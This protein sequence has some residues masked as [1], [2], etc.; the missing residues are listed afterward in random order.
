MKLEAEGESPVAKNEIIEDDDE[1]LLAKIE[2]FI[3]DFM[4][5]GRIKRGNS[6]CGRKNGGG[7][8]AVVRDRG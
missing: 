5:G 1:E 2:V 3:C 8:S 7:Q 4:G 6:K